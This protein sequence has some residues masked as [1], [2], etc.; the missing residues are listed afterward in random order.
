MPPRC[1]RKLNHTLNQASIG[2]GEKKS[3]RSSVTLA[4][5]SVFLHFLNIYF[6]G[7]CNIVNAQLPR[8]AAWATGNVQQSVPINTDVQFICQSSQGFFGSGNMRCQASGSGT[9]EWR[10]S[11]ECQR[12]CFAHKLIFYTWT[13]SLAFLV[14]GKN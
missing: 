6:S 9:L 13:I 1:L 5:A 4:L 12:K 7:E 11:G 3:F 14:G 8:G 10:P 2:I